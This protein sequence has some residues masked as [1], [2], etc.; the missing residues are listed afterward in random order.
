MEQLSVCW[1]WGRMPKYSKLFKTFNVRENNRKPNKK[2]AGGGG[3]NLDFYHLND[4]SSTYRKCY[5]MNVL[6]WNKSTRL[7]RRQCFSVLLFICSAL[8]LISNFSVLYLYVFENISG[9]KLKWPDRTFCYQVLFKKMLIEKSLKSRME[10]L[11]KTRE[12]QKKSTTSIEL[13]SDNFWL[14]QYVFFCYMK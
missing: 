8:G 5:R 2:G 1:G 13:S 3:G 11:V 12:Y 9:N 6:G 10:S 4:S 14:N 7:S